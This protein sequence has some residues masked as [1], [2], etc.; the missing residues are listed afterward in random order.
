MPTGE[1]VTW[2]Q[3]ISC[4]LTKVQ[5]LGVPKETYVDKSKYVNE[6]HVKT[7]GNKSDRPSASQVED[8]EVG[9]QVSP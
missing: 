1:L 2:L 6:K 7:L 8:I 4:R 3:L 5:R 9:W